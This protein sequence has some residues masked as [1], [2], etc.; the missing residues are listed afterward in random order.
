MTTQGRMQN[1]GRTNILLESPSFIENFIK[2]ALKDHPEVD[3]QGKR[4][5]DLVRE[6]ATYLMNQGF[7]DES[8]LV[9]LTE[10]R[11]FKL[12]KLPLKDAIAIAKAAESWGKKGISF[13]RTF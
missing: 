3:W 5:D 2:Y 6:Y 11:L 10:K 13:F 8:S 12:L 4:K 1:G 7:V 9:H